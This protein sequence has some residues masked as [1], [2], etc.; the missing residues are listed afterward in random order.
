MGTVGKLKRVVLKLIIRPFDRFI[1][2][3]LKIF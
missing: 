3:F 2:V 1:E